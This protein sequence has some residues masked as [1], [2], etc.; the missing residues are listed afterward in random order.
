MVHPRIQGMESPR[1]PGRII[2]SILTSWVDRDLDSRSELECL[3]RIR[4]LVEAF[5][6]KRLGEALGGKEL[7]EYSVLFRAVTRCDEQIEKH[8]RELAR[9]RS[10]KKALDRIDAKTVTNMNRYALE[11]R[12]LGAGTGITAARRK[13]D[14]RNYLTSCIPAIPAWIMPIDRVAQFFPAQLEMFDVVIVDEASQARLESIFL[15]ALSKRVVI[16]GDHKQVSPD[17]GMLPV[18]EIEQIVHRHLADDPRKANWSNPDLSLFDECKVAF[19][20]MVTLTEHRRCVPEIIGFS[21]QIAYIPE[22]IRLIPV[23]QT[24][25]EGLPPVKTM[26]VEN[27]FVRGGPGKQENQ[28]E[29]EVI[30]KE[31][32]R[33]TKDP[34]YRGLTLGV[35]TLQGSKQQELIRNRLIDLLDPAEMESRQ[36]RVGMPPDFQG[37]ERN[38]I[39]LSMVMAPNARFAAQTR[40]LMVQRYNV[41]ASRAKDQLVLVHSLRSSDIKNPADLRRQLIDYCQNMEKGLRNPVEGSVGMV[42]NDERVEP[43]ESL[44]EQRVHNRIVER[45][46]KVIPQFEPQIDGHDYRIDLVVVGPYGKYAIECDGDFWHGG[47]DAFAKDLMRQEI[48]Q[49]CG[50]KFFRVP[51]SRFYGDP[52]YMDE[53][54][55]QLEK[56]VA[57]RAPSQIDPKPTQILVEQAMVA[58]RQEVDE[59]EEESIDQADFEDFEARSDGETLDSRVHV[60]MNTTVPQAEPR[61]IYLDGVR[62]REFPKLLGSEYGWLQVYNSWDPEDTGKLTHIMYATPRIFDD[63]LSIVRIEGPI[64][65]SYLMRRHYKATGGSS[66]SSSRETE[67]IAQLKKILNRGELKAEEQI[68]G[69]TLASA[70]FRL[71]EQAPV[72]TRVRG[73]RD[74]YNVPPR[75]IAIIIKGVL[76]SNRHLSR[77]KD[78]EILFRK[79]LHLLDFTKLTPKASEHMN[80]IMATYDKEINSK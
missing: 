10:W 76:R 51:E 62:V 27:G 44:F 34:A 20:N 42:S 8:V 48:L 67:Y 3:Q 57:L 14:I 24:G 78:N 32:L 79:V 41:A 39:L 63:L 56:F 22:N 29:S 43:F 28:P 59:S 17:G 12:K 75:E 60:E 53:L 71:P 18:A 65:G 11:S 68:S 2:I 36:I 16:V 45:G 7:E 61:Q 37:S 13:R 5:K 15:L 74:L 58:V 30:V 70:T 38:V 52:T 49:R 77:L 40:E 4:D 21:N 1:F 26:F 9:R 66:L 64:L 31:V 80:R 23:R 35:V 25:S 55:P 19:G 72:I 73:P 33:M 6:W 46:Y 50:W 47:S 69:D 54:W